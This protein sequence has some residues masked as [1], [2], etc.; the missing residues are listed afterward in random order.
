[1][2]AKPS[3][4]RNAVAIPAATTR[5]FKV[6]SAKRRPCGPATH[7][8]AA[9]PHPPIITPAAPAASEMTRL[10]T[11]TCCKRFTTSCAERGPDRDLAPPPGRLREDDAGDVRARQRHD[12]TRDDGE[13]EQQ[14]RNLAAD[15][16]DQWPDDDASL[17]VRVGAPRR[18]AMRDRSASA[19]ALVTPGSR[20]AV[21]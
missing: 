12:E 7:L 5:Q 19:C 20:R 1:M 4:R 16:F 15:L 14:K 2:S 18:L 10:S 6:A 3:G 9:S 21:T 8:S 13:K 11:A 17:R